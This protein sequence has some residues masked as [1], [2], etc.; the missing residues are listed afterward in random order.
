MA[1][2]GREVRVIIGPGAFVLPGCS[3]LEMVIESVFVQPVLTRG[4]RPK[5]FFFFLYARDDL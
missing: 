5:S 2:G 3:V 1:G 4:C